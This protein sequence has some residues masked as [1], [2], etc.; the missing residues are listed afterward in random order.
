MLAGF[1][2]KA[3]GVGQIAALGKAL[4]TFAT[5]GLVLTGVGCGVNAVASHGAMKSEL[6]MRRDSDK[7][8]ARAE[9]IEEKAD[10]RISDEYARSLSEQLETWRA[11]DAALAK[12][13]GAESVAR[14]EGECPAN[15]RIP[16]ALRPSKMGLR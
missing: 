7:R 10:R 15:C 2:G 9:R 1:F 11:K 6:G 4:V 16:D 5:L 12:L 8:N 14:A 13:A 3:F